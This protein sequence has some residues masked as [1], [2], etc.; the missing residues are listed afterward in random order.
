MAV[1]ELSKS[2]EIE[3]EIEEYAIVDY[4]PEAKELNVKGEANLRIYYVIGN[5]VRE[6]EEFT[7]GTIERIKK[8]MPVHWA[9]TPDQFPRENEMP[10]TALVVIPD[11]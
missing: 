2:N 7:W 5:Q 11:G 8:I 4:T 9:N 1:P 6:Q 3:V 10:I